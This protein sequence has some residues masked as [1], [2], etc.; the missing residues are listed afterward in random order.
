LKNV[1]VWF[2]SLCCLLIIGCGNDRV[3]T[4]QT[5]YYRGMGIINDT[6]ALVI[7]EVV[8]RYNDGDYSDFVGY[9]FEM[10][11]TRYSY[12]YSEH[13]YEDFGFAGVG[14]LSD[15]TFLFVGGSDNEDFLF[16][17]IG[18]SLNSSMYKK[19]TWLTEKRNITRLEMVVRRWN[20]N[21]LIIQSSYY[22]K[23]YNNVNYIV[24]DTTALTLASVDSSEYALLNA[25]DDFQ[26][27]NNELV[28][29]QNLEDTCGFMLIKESGDTLA[30]HIFDDNCSRLTLL[31][32]SDYVTVLGDD[33]LLIF[34]VGLDGKISN[35]PLFYCSGVGEF[36][37]SEGNRI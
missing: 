16:W 7:K 3:Y 14:Q 4:G 37:D 34:S 28:F 19:Y 24:M 29:L 36:Y 32:K 6:T 30:T 12:V 9:N 15:S 21:K 11:D 27:F 33:M 1:V 5:F 17:K 2:W 13:L 8:D 35:E 18:D 10:R 26:M 31:Y 20:D 25:Y 22:G 23:E